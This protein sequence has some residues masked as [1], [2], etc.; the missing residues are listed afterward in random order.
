MTR[1]IST[2]HILAFVLGFAGLVLGLPLAA[3]PVTIAKDTPL[4][5]QANASASVVAQVKEGTTGD[6]T[7]KQ[8]P[9][10]NVK[11]AAG[12]GWMLTVN[13]RFGASAGGTKSASS[14]GDSMSKLFGARQASTGTT[15][16]GIRGLDKADLAKAS[17]DKGQ[18]DL[19]DNYSATRQDGESSAS[20]SG[21]SATQLS[22][23]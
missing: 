4:R 13:V 17:F 11:T 5:A 1:T 14:G 22:Y 8:G 15:T 7:A 6:A 2:R 16:I 21:L 10:L 23:F 19:L 18:L 9:W 3:E 12:T 20:A